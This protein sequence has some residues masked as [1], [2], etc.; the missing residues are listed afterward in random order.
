MPIGG[1]MT[2]ISI[3]RSPLCTYF[4]DGRIENITGTLGIFRDITERKNK[5]DSL[6]K[7][8]ELYREIL[9]N[10]QEGYFELDLNYTLSFFNTTFCSIM[11]KSSNQLQG[12]DFLQMTVPEN[13]RALKSL[14]NLVLFQDSSSESGRFDF[15]DNPTRNQVL[16]LS[17]TPRYEQGEV[18][19]VRGIVRDITGF[20]EAENQ[21]KQLE[22]QLQQAQKLES[23]GTLAGGIAH[24]F[25]N[26]LFII[27]GYTDLAIRDLRKKETRCKRSDASKIPANGQK[28]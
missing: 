7:S 22:K 12:L 28:T 26:I 16:E 5:E 3:I 2:H 14:I 15:T 13:R 6:R 24:D 25:N 27:Q 1:W 4:D 9:E 23:I 21:K 17:I 20:I 8:E 18:T 19:G 10:I 11:K